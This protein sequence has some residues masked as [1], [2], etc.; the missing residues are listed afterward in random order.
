MAV[1][2]LLLMIGGFIAAP[3]VYVVKQ[4]PPLLN[5]ALIDFVANNPF[6]SKDSVY[7]YEPPVNNYTEKKILTHPVL[8]PFDPNTIGE[9]GWVKLGVHPRTIRTIIHYRNK[10]GHFRSPEDIRKIWGLHKEAADH[11]IPFVKIEI[12]TKTIVYDSPKKNEAK[13]LSGSTTKRKEIMAF[14]INTATVEI[15]KSLPGIGDVLANRIVKFRD[16]IGGFVSIDQVKKTYGI[17]DSVFQWMRPFLLMDLSNLPKLNL[18]TVSAHDLKVR[19]NMSYEMAR[20][21]IN[22][23]QQNGAYRSV[24]DIKNIT[25]IPDTVFQKLILLVKTDE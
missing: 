16:K 24:Q 12:P 18:N 1:I 15:W 25:G 3:Y 7:T 11:L 5:K 10:G 14:D 22:Y 2:L 13:P 23:R 21:I 20:A 8:F 6:A 17:S 9:E 19:V 4:E